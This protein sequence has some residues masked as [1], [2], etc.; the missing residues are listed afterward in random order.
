MIHDRDDG[1]KPEPA[2]GDVEGRQVAEHL[3]RVGGE[4]NFL[5]CLPQ[6]GILEGLSRFNDTARQRDL[7]AVAHVLRAN[8]ENKVRMLANREQQ[9]QPGCMPHAVGV[10]PGRPVAARAR[11]HPG[12]RAGARQWLLKS[13][14]ENG[15]ELGVQQCGAF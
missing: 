15:N 3:R 4:G 10:E 13:A 1:V 8:R 6:R 12:L 5:V 7:P 9:Q 14:G 11:R 2:D